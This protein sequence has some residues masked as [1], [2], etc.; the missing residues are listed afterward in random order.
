MSEILS[1]QICAVVASIPNCDTSDPGSILPPN[2]WHPA[3]PTVL[4]FRLDFLGKSS[5]GKPLRSRCHTCPVSQAVGYYPLEAQGL[6]RHMNAQV[7]QN[8]V[9]DP[10]LPLL[11]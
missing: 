4:P 8:L 2:S 6:M 9:Y 11:T 10:S 5:G 3:Q 7:M 1:K